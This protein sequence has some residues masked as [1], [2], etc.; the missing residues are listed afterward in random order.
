MELE[1]VLT[2]GAG[3]GLVWGATYVAQSV[4]DRLFERWV[5]LKSRRLEFARRE[6]ELLLNRVRVLRPDEHG[7]QG[8]IFDGQLY[9]NLDSMAVFDQIRVLYFDPLMEQV[10]AMQKTLLAMQGISHRAAVQALETGH[11][12]TPALMWPGR[13][14]LADLFGD[15]RPSIHDLIIG[16]RPSQEG[17]LD[18]VRVGIHELMHTLAVGVSGW[19]KSTWLRAIL[20]QIAQV[21]EPVEVVAVDAYGSEFNLLRNWGKLHWP[22]ARTIEEAKAVL[23]AVSDEIE[24]RKRLFEDNAPIASKLAEYNQ[25]TGAE[26]PP[27]LVVID[28][29]TALLNQPGVG[30]PLRAAVQTARQYGVY[31]LV[32]GQSAKHSVIDTQIRDNFTSRL[33]FRTSPT[34][35]RVVLDDKAAS[36]LTDQGRMYAQL[37]GRPLVE[38]QGPFVSRQ[39]FMQALANGGPRQDLPSLIDETAEDDDLAEQIRTLHAQGE[40]LRSIQ[41]ALFGYVG[42]AAYDQVK[43]VLA[44]G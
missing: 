38:L 11:G 7:R 19:G 8:I 34:S 42:G 27:W 18:V 24:R 10:N 16:V 9:R 33:C 14:R 37:V 41:K 30:E 15:R 28:E 6:Q 12:D 25:A 23:A 36:E 13:V 2:I 44:G 32:A 29:G 35:S 21:Q 26:L 40:S 3:G 43:Q 1:T 4:Y 17:G 20:W 5:Q 31:I 22:V 39:E